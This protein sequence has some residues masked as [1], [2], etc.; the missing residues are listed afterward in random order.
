MAYRLAID[1]GGTFTDLIMQ[2]EKGNLQIVKVASTPRNPATAL[3]DSLKLTAEQNGTNISQL[4]S[5]CEIFVHGTTVA[6]NAVVEQKRAKTGLICTE[7]FRHVLFTRDGGRTN[8]YD[9]RVDY[10]QPLVPVYLTLPVRERINSEGGIEVPLDEESVLQA[11]LQFKKWNVKAIGV[12]LLWSIVNPIHER[13]IGEIIREVWPDADYSLSHEV[14]PIIREYQRT[15]ATVLDASL[16]PIMKGYI[17]ELQE[18]LRANGLAQEVLVTNCSSG[19]MPASGIV[20]RP[21]YVID[22]GPAMGPIVGK[23]CGEEVGT[24]NVIV[25][26]MGGTSFDMSMIIDGAI[27]VSRMKTIGSD[28]VGITMTEV[29]AIGAGGGSIAWVDEGGLL[30]VGPTSAGADPGPACYGRGGQDPTVTDAD[31]LLGYLNK[32]N[33]VGGRLKL[34]PELS[35]R[36][37]EQKIA[38]ALGIEVQ[39]AANAIVQVVNENMVNG[40]EEISVKRGL[41]PRDFLFVVFGGAGPTHAAAIARSLKM[42]RVYIPRLAAG[43]CALGM[44]LSNIKFENLASYFTDSRGFDFV[45]VNRVLGECESRGRASLEKQNIAP[46]NVRFEY[47]VEA[48]YPMQV[49]GLEI[50]VGGW[51]VTPELLH[52]MTESFHRVHDERYGSREEGQFVEFTDWRVVAIGDIPRVK[53]PEQDYV[54]EDATPALKGKREVF[55]T[56]AGEFVETPVYDGSRLAHGNRMEGPAIIEEAT[57]TVVVPPVSRLIVNRW[58]DYRMELD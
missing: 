33:Y 57:T 22:S 39:T 51:E 10:C 43:G 56:E 28:P 15:C 25:A 4:L 29:S 3:F 34:Y 35:Y 37:I 54:G 19:M 52:M 9:M 26:D 50:P 18:S 5:N 40:I 30:H 2:D 17:R 38:R 7:G 21:V 44:L 11:I 41:D 23:L 24:G 55:F 32:D 16:K 47:F 6:T 49:Y 36:V 31:L 12:C 48:R 58:G 14:Q 45:G 20:E 46:E 42:T 53:L 1:T 8:I 27:A 13:R